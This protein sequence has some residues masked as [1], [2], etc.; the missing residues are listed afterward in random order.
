MPLSASYGDVMSDYCLI[1]AFLH[2]CL[3]ELDGAFHLQSLCCC[4]NEDALACLQSDGV[5][6]IVGDGA[7]ALESDEDDEAVKLRIVESHRLVEVVNGC[8]EVRALHEAHTLILHRCVVC[9][10]VALYVI[11]DALGSLLCVKL[12]V[13]A[14]LVLTLEVVDAVCNVA[15]LL[16][17]GE[18]TAGADG[19]DASDRKSV[20]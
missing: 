11:V 13:I 7:F 9:T 8:I 5:A 2:V 12:A 4:G 16:N 19:V 14:V 15:G 20:V 3:E 18:E 17:F 6:L 10:V 1:S